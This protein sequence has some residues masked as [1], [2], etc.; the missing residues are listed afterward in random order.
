ML[1][2]DYSHTGAPI[3]PDLRPEFWRDYQRDIIDAPDFLPQGYH[4]S[5]GNICGG[6]KP[7]AVHAI[8]PCAFTSPKDRAPA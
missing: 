5:S 7:V 4:F 6:Y 8:R 2:N 1:I 3:S